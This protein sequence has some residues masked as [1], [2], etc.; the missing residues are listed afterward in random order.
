[1]EA[2]C[3]LPVFGMIPFVNGNSKLIT[4]GEDELGLMAYKQPKSP[5]AEAIYHIRTS[6][7]LSSA[8]GAPAAIMITS[9]NPNEGKTTISLN[10]ASALAMNNRKVV[11]L[12]ADLRKPS[13]HSILQEPMQPGLSNFLTG[14]ASLAEIIRP[15]EIP[16]L[17]FISAGTT[18]PNPIE[19][20]SS[21]A[22]GNLLKKLRQD[23]RHLVLDTPPILGFTDG[24]A[25]SAL[26][27]GA[28]LI[29]KHNYTRRENGLLA[30][31]L[32]AQVNAPILGGILN[33][34]RKDRLGY[35]ER[36]GYYYY[37][38]YYNE[39]YDTVKLP[40]RDN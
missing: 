23:F 17:F 9:P 13:L 30:M 37:A 5:M 4:L 25:I 36:Y 24:R 20:L 21:D 12:D 16:N 14:T 10:I 11:I 35:G 32:L 1:M 33:M 3:R 7:M 6:I 19:L 22:F 34:A 27:D 38:K 31:Q 29:F 26:V 40:D 39:Y 2:F 15:T 28:I 18:P 8:G